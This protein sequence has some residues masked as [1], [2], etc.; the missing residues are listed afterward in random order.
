MNEP[1]FQDIRFLRQRVIQL[2]ERWKQQ[3]DEEVT[4]ALAEG[5][6]RIALHPR[7]LPSEPVTHLREAHRIDGA[8]PRYAYHL[9]LF[10]FVHGEL[11]A[12]SRWISEAVRRCPTSHRL[13]AHVCILQRELNDRYKTSEEYEPDFLRRTAEETSAGIRRGKDNFAPGSLCFVPPRSL[14][15]REA[16]ARR[17]DRYPPG[18]K[19]SGARL[20]SSAE[21]SS[22]QAAPTRVSRLIGAGKCRW[23]GVFDMEIE[24]LLEQES[25]V[26]TRDRIIPDLEKVAELG[27]ARKDGGTGF[28]ILAI[29]WLLSGYPVATVRR[30]MSECVPGLGEQALGLADEVCRC[31]EVPREDLPDRL[32]AALSGGSLPALVVA[33]VHHHRLLW[34]RLD[35]PAPSVYRKAV[36]LA[37]RMRAAEKRDSELE[38]EAAGIIKKLMDETRRLDEPPPGEMTDARPDETEVTAIT[39]ASAV[40]RLCALEARCRVLVQCQRDGF[41]FLR[42][43]LEPRVKTGLKETGVLQARKDLDCGRELLNVLAGAGDAGVRQLTSLVEQA[44]VL[45]SQALHEELKVRDP[46]DSR[47]GFYDRLE[48]TRN[49]FR[50]LKLPRGFRRVLT[51]LDSAVGKAE[52]SPVA[53]DAVATPAR[54]LE[55]LLRQAHEN[56]PREKVSGGAMDGRQAPSGTAEAPPR[57]GP[58]PGGP[59]LSTDG[60][61]GVEGLTKA[62]AKAD[63]ELD[64]VTSLSLASFDAY[65][66]SRNSEPEL[67]MLQLAVFNRAAETRHRLGRHHEARQFWRRCLSLD[68]LCL[69]ILNNMAVSETLDAGDHARILQSWKSYCEVLY[70]HAIAAG[71]PRLSSRARS[72]FHALYATA[73]TQGFIN[74]EEASVRQDSERGRKFVR[75][76]NQPGCLREFLEHRCAELLNRRFE[77]RTP[78]LLLG[79]GRMAGRE[80]REKMRE[81]LAVFTG[82]VCASL[83]ERIRSGFEMVCLSELDRALEICRKPEGLTLAGNPGYAGD[84]QKLIDWTASVY[85]LKNQ[86]FFGFVCMPDP[87]SGRKKRFAWEKHVV[88]LDFLDVLDILARVPLAAGADIREAAVSGIAKPYGQVPGEMVGRLDGFLA[89][90]AGIAAIYAHENPGERMLDLLAH[91]FLGKKAWW[92]RQLDI[93]SKNQ[94]KVYTVFKHIDNGGFLYPGEIKGILGKKDWTPADAERMVNFLRPLHS[95]YPALA[96]PALCLAGIL[97][98]MKRV[99]QAVEVLDHAVSSV[100][101]PPGAEECRKMREKT[102]GVAR[103]S[104]SLET[105]DFDGALDE[106]MARLEQSPLDTSLV[107]SLLGIYRKWSRE[108]PGELAAR[109]AEVEQRLSRVIDQAFPVKAS[110][111]GTSAENLRQLLREKRELVATV[112][113]GPARDLSDAGER[114]RAVSRLEEV[115][116]LDRG[117]LWVVFFL[118]TGYYKTGVDIFRSGRGDRG[119][120]VLARADRLAGQVLDG[121]IEENIK[122]QARR[123]REETARLLA[124]V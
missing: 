74:Q 38:E 120:A 88:S 70:F 11:D 16:E 97:V 50:E 100:M 35:Y 76:L 39:V 116:K 105:G 6:F 13:R 61:T 48:T 42:Q 110:R 71:A 87:D 33:L 82:E 56:T 43:D 68:P 37:A 121:D 4:G 91:D 114:N 26:R 77:I 108:K 41:D 85:R 78:T 94:A 63:R 123:I 29:Q 44:S 49:S 89:E 103:L 65:G 2:K 40:E 69:P 84:E 58:V 104:A 19:G 90:A 12:A 66:P 96:G 25:S 60:L 21:E 7:A 109:A 113:L 32:A 51:H 107:D 92:R 75:L 98:R 53:E 8:N 10:F 52:S 62:V 23:S 18:G 102:T 101:Y 27:P 106:A 54:R 1:A 73:F 122:A 111:T 86:F 36:K 28:V 80:K 15:S 115:Y 9:A 22:P 55:E 72:D 64:R 47:P 3:P 24:W 31:F 118:A 117:N 119:H 59:D 95:R 81:E 5:H 57:K 45:E 14:A 112:A 67:V 30:L 17:G 34:R 46:G 124:A 83:P 20:D 79:V 99:D 93:L